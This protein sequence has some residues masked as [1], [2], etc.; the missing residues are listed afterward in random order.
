MEGVSPNGYKWIIAEIDG[1]RVERAGV[2]EG[3]GFYGFLYL[4]YNLIW[5]FLVEEGGKIVF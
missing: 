5:L 1:G 2:P 4:A 3:A